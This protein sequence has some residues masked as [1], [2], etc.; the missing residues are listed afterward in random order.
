VLVSALSG[1]SSYTVALVGIDGTVVASAQASTPSAV[2]CGNGAAAVVPPP[3]S[4]SNTRVYFMDGTGV[5]HFLAPNGDTG[6]ATTVPFGQTRRSMFAVSPDDK[7]IAVIVADFTATGT[8]TSVADVISG[9]VVPVAAQGDC[10]GRIP[11]HSLERSR[12]DNLALGTWR[13]GWWFS[14]VACGSSS[15]DW[16]NAT[17]PAT[18]A[19]GG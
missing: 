18:S 4:T 8:S 13:S 16:V 2:R 15:L 10:A 17:W 19:L 6:R 7:R 3:V 5:V 1:S 12:W 14:L 9:K 11:G